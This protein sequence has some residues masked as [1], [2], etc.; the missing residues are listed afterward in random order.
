MAVV[1][2]GV[3][4]PGDADRES[5]E[6]G[7][8]TSCEAPRARVAG[9]RH[10]VQWRA[11]AAV[12]RRRS[13]EH[14][15]GAQAA[16]QD[17]GAAEA[18]A[19][20]PAVPAAALGFPTPPSSGEEGRDP[21]DASSFGAPAP[22]LRASTDG[23]SDRLVVPP[24]GSAPSRPPEPPSAPPRAPLLSAPPSYSLPPPPARSLASPRSLALAPDAPTA[25]DA[26][27]PAVSF[28]PAPE[29]RSG[30]SLSD[31]LDV[32]VPE[33]G[34]EL[35]LSSLA[36]LREPPPGSASPAPL[37]PPPA[38]APPSGEIVPPP[39]LGL[40][41]PGD[42][43]RAPV[44]VSELLGPVVARPPATLPPRASGAPRAPGVA[45]APTHLSR[46][47]DAPGC[48][49]A[50]GY[51]RKCRR[52]QR[53]RSTRQWRVSPDLHLYQELFLK[54][55]LARRIEQAAASEVLA[56]TRVSLLRVR[57]HRV[58]LLR[59]NKRRLRRTRT[60]LA[61]A[62]RA[63]PAAP[64]LSVAAH[65]A[66][67]PSPVSR[68]PS[69]AAPP[70]SSDGARPSDQL[71]PLPSASTAGGAVLGGRAPSGEPKKLAGRTTASASPA[72]GAVRGFVPWACA[73]SS[74]GFVR[75]S[76]LSAHG[77]MKSA[78]RGAG[79]NHDGGGS[80]ARGASRKERLATPRPPPSAA[81]GWPCLGADRAK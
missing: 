38:P 12:L 60:R 72:G 54:L 22:V 24:H 13:G 53:P 58:A 33:G 80:T 76:A 8:A 68:S 57:S 42:R 50:G 20:P 39:S 32:P 9:P 23:V 7:S 5:I 70:P 17:E 48:S 66:S 46:G 67:A 4:S 6:R 35:E 15:R 37:V 1:G 81:T 62:A 77:S 59:T 27:S 44:P 36:P 30:A 21:S 16:G 10:P 64:P 55:L 26:R 75:S 47:C 41:R 69:P 74:G 71:R 34:L 79:K 63:H 31:L 25:P 73:A 65:S 45:A 51:L 43:R 29:A 61:A 2:G 52:R 40:G 14:P 18:G 56:H 78:P 28:A 3:Q 11:A 49:R 19:K